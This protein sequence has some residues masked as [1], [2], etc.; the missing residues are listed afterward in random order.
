MDDVT[1][2]QTE[3]CVKGCKATRELII[4]VIADASKQKNGIDQWTS[5]GVF[6][7]S[8]APVVTSS[9]NLTIDNNLKAVEETPTG[10]PKLL[11]DTCGQQI[12][13]LNVQAAYRKTMVNT[14]PSSIVQQKNADNVVPEY[15]QT[16][17]DSYTIIYHTPPGGT[18]H[19]G[20]PQS[21]NTSNVYNYTYVVMQSGGSGGG[22]GGGNGG[23]GGGDGGGDGDGDGE[24]DPQTQTCEGEGGGDCDP[25]TEECSDDSI[26]G[27]TDCAAPPAC[28]GNPIECYLAKQAWTQACVFKKPTAAEIRETIQQGFGSTERGGLLQKAGDDIDVAK[29]F[30]DAAATGEGRCLSDVSIDLAPVGDTITLPLS[31]FCD[32]LSLV[33]VMFL[34]AVAF[35]CLRIVAEGW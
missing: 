20:G 14:E 13:P 1:P 9:T 28:D 19:V 8:G 18:Y 6:C 35:F 32:V 30:D 31:Q 10:K 27:G 3:A 16:G 29:W 17:P 5:T 2:G 34:I 33:R 23:G 15:R 26:G 25:E 4:T 11:C 12:D 22:G 7:T 21:F 24:C